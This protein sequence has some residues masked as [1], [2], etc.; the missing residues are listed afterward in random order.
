MKDF[1]HIEIVSDEMVV[2]L[3]KK[4]PAE[5]LAIGDRMFQQARRMMVASIKQSYPDWSENQ[6]DREIVRRM[7]GVELP[8]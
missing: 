8:S 5:R 7:H 3:Q 2:I 4:T 1:S 6:V